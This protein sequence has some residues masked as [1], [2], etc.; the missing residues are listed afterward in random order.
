MPQ[1][2][3]LMLAP[4]LGPFGG[5]QLVA[6]LAAIRPEGRATIGYHRRHGNLRVALPRRTNA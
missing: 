6:A 1:M 5:D 3:I 2:T 4:I